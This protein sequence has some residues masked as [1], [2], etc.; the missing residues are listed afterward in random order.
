LVLSSCGGADTASP[1]LTLTETE[2]TY[3]GSD[4]LPSTETFE[5][6]VVNESSKLG[7]FEIVKIDP[8]HTFEEVERYMES[9]RQ[10]LAEGLEIAGPPSYLTLGARTQAESGG[11]GTLV[12]TVTSGTWILWC[13]HEHPPTALFLIAPPLAVA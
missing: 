7:A 5:A 10:R 8:G 9:E 1:R 2:C 12:S 11:T 6:E 3:D 13:A 4:A